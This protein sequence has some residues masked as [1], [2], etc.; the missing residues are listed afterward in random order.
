MPI[1]ATETPVA[2]S[3]APHAHHR[4]V[5]K[6]P[7]V[8]QADHSDRRRSRDRAEREPL[9]ADGYSR[10]GRQCR[11]D[12]PLRHVRQG[13][14]QEAEQ[15]GARGCARRDGRRWIGQD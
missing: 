15:E 12:R 14:G 2:Q 9:H 7:R 3:L 6:F 11:D 8:H 10:H 1:I 13:D 5:A 4:H